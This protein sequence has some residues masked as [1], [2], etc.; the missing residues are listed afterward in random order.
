MNYLAGLYLVLACAAKMLLLL[1]PA[2]VGWLVIVCLIKK[3]EPGPHHQPGS[4]KD[5]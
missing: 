3:Q 1:S 2:L 5:V 4:R